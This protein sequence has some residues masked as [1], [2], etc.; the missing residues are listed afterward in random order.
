MHTDFINTPLIKQK[1]Y[2]PAYRSFSAI[3]RIGQ[4]SRVRYWFIGILLVIIAVLFLPWTQN[5]RATGLTTTLR[6]EQRPQQMNT[7]IA[8]RV[9]K[10]H[11]KEGDMV[12]A[13]DTIVQLSEIKTDYLDPNL[14]GRTQ[15]QLDAKQSAMD[16][17]QGKAGAAVTQ[18]SSLAQA[19][20]LKIM[21][22]QNKLR[23]LELKIESDSAKSDAAEREFRLASEQLRRQNILKDSGLVSQMQ[24]EQRQLSFQTASAKRVVALN[25]YA[26]TRTD[27]INT[28]IEL[29]QTEQEYAEKIAKAD[30]DRYQSLSQIAGNQGDIAKLRNQFASYSIRNGM[31]YITAPQDGQVVQAKKA[32]IG[33]VVKEGEMI[34]EIVPRKMDYAVE[35]FVRPVDL[36]LISKGQKVRLAFDGFPAI[37]FSGWPNTSYGMFGGVVVAVENVNSDN[38]KFR[39]LIAED[40]DDRPWPP[41]LRVGAGA[42]GIALLKNVPVWYELWRNING[43]PPDYYKKAEGN[44]EKKK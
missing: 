19:R 30:G 24:L 1:E 23:Q 35:I 2:F 17:Y 14:L 16:Y 33:E 21:Q 36:P 38:G 6:P 18:A 28:R 41:T 12:K 34:V 40:K 20:G 7:L 15:E 44:N 27:L 42:Q 5:I 22:L 3:Y 29:S 9:E 39:I 31:Y 26:N 32:G 13:G 4:R 37:V 43:F 10:W 11:V 25:E 8:G